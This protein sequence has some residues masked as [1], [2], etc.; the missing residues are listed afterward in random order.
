MTVQNLLIATI[1]NVR[2]LLK[3]ATKGPRAAAIAQKLTKTHRN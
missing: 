2:K 1:Q 3:Y